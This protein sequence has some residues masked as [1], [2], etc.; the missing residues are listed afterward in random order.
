[1]ALQR[2]AIA[3]I[4]LKTSKDQLAA[5]KMDLAE[6]NRHLSSDSQTRQTI[7]DLCDTQDESSDTDPN[8]KSQTKGECRNCI[9]GSKTNKGRATIRA[10]DIIDLTK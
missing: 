6:A 3:A 1:M 10:I 7:I 9:P 8:N 4:M 2:V 5:A